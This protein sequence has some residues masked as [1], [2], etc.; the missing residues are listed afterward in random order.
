[1][2]VL[3]GCADLLGLA[4]GFRGQVSPVPAALL[5]WRMPRKSDTARVVCRLLT[6]ARTLSGPN[7]VR[8]WRDGRRGAWS[9]PGES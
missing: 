9:T 1:M 8:D 3:A 7:L 6:A 2:N 5:F 4:G